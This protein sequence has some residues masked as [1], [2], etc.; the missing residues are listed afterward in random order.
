M[1]GNYSDFNGANRYYFIVHIFYLVTMALFLTAI[2]KNIVRLL[3]GFYACK[4][5]I[6]VLF[7]IPLFLNIYTLT[8]LDK[9]NCNFSLLPRIQGTNIDKL[10]TSLKDVDYAIVT[11]ENEF[12]IYNFP[13][14]AS[15]IIDSY[16]DSLDTK[17]DGDYGQFV[18]YKGNVM[19]P[20]G[21][22]LV[23]TRL[24]FSKMVWEIPQKQ[25]LFLMLNPN[26]IGNDLRTVLDS[27]NIH[28]GNLANTDGLRR[29][30]GK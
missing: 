11:S 7:C 19:Y 15:Y 30:F 25:V 5:I 21:F 3:P 27:I 1:G 23:G 20:I 13:D 2:Y 24:S 14:K 29:V 10:K 12:T 8:N 18:K 22:R 26:H 16:P 4:I 9:N 6:F 17:P 28:A